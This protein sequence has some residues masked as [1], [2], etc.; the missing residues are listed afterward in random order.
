MVNS[1]NQNTEEK[2]SETTFKSVA[3]ESGLYE[4]PF[5][6]L[7]DYLKCFMNCKVCFICSCNNFL[8]FKEFCD[9]L[10]LKAVYVFSDDEQT[11]K[12]FDEVIDVANQVDI[13]VC[14]DAQSVNYS[15][16]L[17]MALKV[18]CQYFFLYMPP[19]DV[20]LPYYDEFN[21]EDIVRCFCSPIKNYIIAY[22]LPEQTDRQSLITCFASILSYYTIF[23]EVYVN[24]HLFKQ[25]LD[26]SFLCKFDFYTNKIDQL[27]H[28][29]YF[30]PA[31]YLDKLYAFCLDFSAFIEC[32]KDVFNKEKTFALLYKY[33]TPKTKLTEF[34]LSC[35]SAQIFS[36]IYLDFFK[37]NQNFSYNYCSLEKKEAMYAKY[38]ASCT[39]YAQNCH[40]QKEDE[41]VYLI[42]RFSSKLY[43]KCK[44]FV[45]MF[46]KFI[47]ASL[48]L[49]ADSG[50]ALI[51]ELNK[52]A[53]VRTIYFVP[54]FCANKS[55]LKVIQDYGILDSIA[56]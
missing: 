31:D 6:A 34:E 37:N 26:D 20:F 39:C 35:F 24:A 46:D 38:F 28:E 10:Y 21:G 3:F 12:N 4:E 7:R 16:K 8:T 53:I 14:L 13:I 5:E 51:K 55:L 15:K 36:H 22:T 17:S 49:Y 18:A 45:N 48:D 27:L 19:I 44:T 41:V 23:L 56:E 42:N 32:F 43:N 1:Y 25:K 50:Y 54:D 52:K 29:I 2:Q 11:I 33:L 40:I 30:M 47:D 9:S